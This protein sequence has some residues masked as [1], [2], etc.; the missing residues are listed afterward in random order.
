MSFHANVRKLTELHGRGTQVTKPLENL[1][2]TLKKNCEGGHPPY[3]RGICTKCRPPVLTLNRQRFRHVDNITIENEDVVNR[4]LDFWRRSSHQRVG[5]LIGRYEPFAEVPL[6][7]KAV[8]AA[9]YEPPQSSTDRSVKFEQDPHAELVNEL[10]AWLGM[11]RVGWIF[12]DLWS[13]DIA[14]GTVHCTRHQESFLLSA[15]ECVTAGDLQNHHPNYT[16]Y[17]ADGHFGSKFVTVVAS[18][19]QSKHIHFSG[20]QVSNQCAAMVDAEILVPTSNPELAWVRETPLRPDHY[21]TDVQ[22]TEKDEYGA[23]VR[24][25]GRPMPVEYLLVDVPAGMPIE[26]QFSFHAAAADKGFPIENRELVNQPQ[27]LRSVARYAADFSENQFLELASNFHFLL[28]LLTNTHVQFPKEDVRALCKIVT[29]RDRAKAVDW[30]QANPTWGTL[31]ELLRNQADDAAVG[32]DTS[33][34]KWSCRHCTFENTERRDDC[35]VCG[36][37]S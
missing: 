21:I 30:A 25:N 9:V 19:D 31:R 26:P 23:E 12:T 20:Y 10:C 34:T 18:G 2:L 22:F 33:A 28:F 5:Y 35:A 8:V 17:C 11:K 16:K 14:A 32:A 1:S 29:E 13:A 4:F 37:P 27:D 3:P 36:L 7:I 6:G 24:R 15:E